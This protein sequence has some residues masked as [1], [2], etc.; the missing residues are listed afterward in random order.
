M[1]GV[2]ACARVSHRRELAMSKAS[3]I[4]SAELEVLDR[5]YR[6]GGLRT[7][8]SPHVRYDDPACTHSGCTHKMEW[9]DFNLELH[10]DPEGID[11]PLVSPWWDGRGFVGRCPGCRHWIRFTTLGM[12][13]I[14]EERAG[15]YPRLPDHWHC[16]AQFA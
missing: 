4:S 6:E 10:G 9:I 12:E 13:A 1:A 11:R 15:Q 8:A 14:L 2:D 5:F 3:T 16:L 7:M